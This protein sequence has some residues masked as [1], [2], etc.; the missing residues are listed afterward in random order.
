MYKWRVVQIRLFRRVQ[1]NTAIEQREKKGEHGAK[2]GKG[3]QRWNFSGL[4]PGGREREEF[5]P[6]CPES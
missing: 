3:G 2:V 1:K 6:R 4:G 5:D